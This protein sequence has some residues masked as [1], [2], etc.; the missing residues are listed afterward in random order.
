MGK[1]SDI[2]P[3]A[4][5]ARGERHK[6]TVL[7]VDVGADA[8]LARDRLED[9]PLLPPTRVRELDLAVQP[10]RAQQRRVERVG[11][12]RRHDDLDVDVLV[13]P[14]HLGQEFDQDPLHFAVGAGLG[15]ETLRRDRV[16]LRAWGERG[17]SLGPPP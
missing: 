12:V 2:V 11:A 9:Q 8:H 4:G 17:Q 7:E 13:E 10:P 16:D 1:V 6:L 5:C 14:V 15:V 3:G